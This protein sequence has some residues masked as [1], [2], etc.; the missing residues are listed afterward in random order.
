MGI[1]R[2]PAGHPLASAR[3][4]FCLCCRRDGVLEQVAA[5]TSLP[6]AQ[7]ASAL[8]A[9]ATHPAVLR[10]LAA[11]LEAD[12]DALAHGAPP[13][14]GRLV[15]ELIGRG[16]TGLPVP[17][18]VVCGR[19]GR[20]LTRTD[21]GGMCQRCAARRNPLPC[22]RCGIVKPVAGRTAQM[23]PI[24]ERCRRGERGRRACGRCG[25]VASIAVR[26]RDGQPDVC[27]NCYRLPE[28]VCSVCG[29][30]RECGFAASQRPI[31]L[32]CLPRASVP[33]GRCGADRP[34]TARWEE[35][36]V[37]ERCYTAALRH[38]GRC[39]RCA[40][41][42]RLVAPPGP[43]ADTC[44]DC[45]GQPITHACGDCGLEDKLFEK[46]RCAGCSLR[47]R[48]TDLLS[49]GSGHVPTQLSGV[50]EAICATRT[51]RT[52]LNWLREGAA[53][54]VLAEVA[55]GRLEPTHRA[56]DAHPNPRAADYL[57]HVLVAGGALGHRDEDL[58]RTERWLEDQLAAIEVPAQ[59]QLVK[60]FATW[61][62]MRR[63]RRSAEA[64]PGPRTY[65][66]HAKAN[67]KAAAEFLPGST[68]ETSPWPKP[69]R[70]TSSTG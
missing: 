36:P 43:D 37:C 17:A 64:T 50:L 30:H 21:S 20:P 63:L 9:V 7:V 41:T 42:R 5:A 22:A 10:S 44:A 49:A 28:A 67:I 31:C 13:V 25:K 15:T 39:Q 29:R 51:P 53:A 23:Q 24:C 12:P 46:G 33:C 40:Q 19:V 62:V 34:P 8:D 38:R 11:A 47:R 52:A 56:L 18:C 70:A 57:R 48:A 45:V 2:C 14:V 6:R 4:R 59:R 68:R 32:S 54:A 60:A 27:V 26:A 69:A 35:G 3:R 1:P 16:A 61:R 55:S 66:A 58:A 65:T